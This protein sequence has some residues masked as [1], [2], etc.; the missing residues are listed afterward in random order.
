[1][2]SSLKREIFV[3]HEDFHGPHDTIFHRAQR[4]RIWNGDPSV[5]DK[6]ARKGRIYSTTIPF[7][8]CKMNQ[9][10]IK[11]LLQL[12]VEFRAVFQCPIR[13]LIIWYSEVSKPRDLCLELSD[14]SELFSKRYGNSNYQ[15]RDFD[16]SRDLMKWRL[17]GYWNRAQLS[18]LGLLTSLPRLR[19]I[20]SGN[21]FYSITNL[22]ILHLSR[23]TMFIWHIND[24][25]P[26]KNCMINS[27]D[28]KCLVT[29][30]FSLKIFP[31][32]LS[33]RQYQIYSRCTFKMYIVCRPNVV[34]V[35]QVAEHFT[36]SAHVTQL[37]LSECVFTECFNGTW[38]SCHCP[39]T[40]DACL[41]VNI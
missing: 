28:A 13:R 31:R 25:I 41:L 24:L 12:L 1:M 38:S 11:G 32:N 22:L 19:S 4:S 23:W 20:S 6:S 5:L 21:Q 2:F 9:I 26:K 15:C 17:I 16:T 39:G 8:R 29:I 40:S 35:K 36:N 27:P 37:S 14:R 3:A 18:I 30:T 7:L 34:S 33:L 10:C